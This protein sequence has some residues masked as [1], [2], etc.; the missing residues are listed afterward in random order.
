[1]TTRRIIT[2]DGL[3]GSGKTSISQGLAE[4]LGFA[5][6]NSGSLYRAVGYLAIKQGVNPFDSDAVCRL[7]AENRIELVLDPNGSGTSGCMING[8]FKGEELRTPE[9]SEATSQSSSVPALRELLV[10]SQRLA[11]PGSSLVAEGRDMGTVIFPAAELKF[12]IVVS[13]EVRVMRRITQLY[14]EISSLPPEQQ[15]QIQIDMRREILERDDRDQNRDNSPTKPA[16]DAV[17]VSNDQG[18]LTEIIQN[19][20]DR[21]ASA[22]LV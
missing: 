19:L 17:L 21:A 15:E 9:V 3:A 16:G 8:E 4:K 20:Y 11:Y 13:P 10:D 14:G 22:G 1:M 12:F 18:T 5:H 2:V 6:L 7:V